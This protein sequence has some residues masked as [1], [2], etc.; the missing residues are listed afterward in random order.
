MFNIRLIYLLFFISSI[1]NVFSQDQTVGLFTNDKNAFN[2]YTLFN[3]LQ[4]TTTYLI[5]NCGYVVNSWISD[6]KPNMSVYL[7]DDGN[8]LRSCRNPDFGGRLEILDWEGNVTWS[9]DFDDQ[10]F[11]MHHDIEPLPNGNILILS[12]DT[13]S[14]SE[15]LLEG[16]DPAMLGIEVQAEKIVEIEPL[17][18]NE[19]N[20][21]WE[22][23]IWDHLVQDYDSLKKNY[24]I[25]ADHPELFNINY[26][27][28]A[29]A[30]NSPDWIHA[31]GIAYNPD[32]DQ[33]VLSSRNLS[34]IFVIDHTTD[35][36]EAMG[37]TGGLYGKGGDILYRFGNPAAY[38]RGTEEDQVLFFQHDAQWVPPGYPD[39]G[40]IIIFNNLVSDTT[41]SVVII[42]PPMDSAGYYSDPGVS[43]YD[44]PDFAWAFES[45]E[46][47]SKH[48]S[49][50]QQLPNG[51]MLI[52]KG[53][54]GMIF[55]VDKDGNL[56]WKY[57]NPE[58]SSGPAIQGKVPEMN[59][60]FKCK[61][62][63]PDFPGFD[64]KDLF[65]G[66]PIELE[67]WPSV[68]QVLEDTVASLDLKVFLQGP[69][70]GLTMDQDLKNMGAIPT[71][72]PYNTPP[73]NYNGTEAVKELPDAP[74]V[75]WLLIEFRD[76]TS[77]DLSTPSTIIDRQAAFLLADGSVVGLDGITKLIFYNTINHQVY[78]TAMHRNH[79][80]ILSAFPVSE[81]GGY[82]TYDFSTS[83]NKVFNNALGHVELSPGIWGMIGGDGNKDQEVNKLDIMESWKIQAGLKGYLPADFNLNYQVGNKDKNDIWLLNN[84][85]AS[86]VPQ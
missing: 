48:I 53:I 46:I 65:P 60:V 10:N 42:T 76:A 11:D 68:C 43:S 26:S 37:H 70:N 57:V 4:S 22:W 21:V 38:N 59:N 41:S 83:E 72:Q 73:W 54:D 82:L 32:L 16:R 31:N 33:I 71:F 8:L 34:E 17:E 64:G 2:G 66:D 18:D 79:L 6:Y 67:P 14:A 69:Y 58:G 49:G 3:P 5:D 50:T 7:L 56:L 78:I 9:F 86:Q 85:K 81:T 75:D 28:A 77:P 23:T 25:V 40:K 62:Y 45:V 44:P 20:I 35:L 52:C 13:Y 24:G 84:K 1:L 55:E 47:H 63:G 36:E 27:A 51:N 80:G 29:L 15:A 19:I 12:H 61:R 74:I 39:E 30:S